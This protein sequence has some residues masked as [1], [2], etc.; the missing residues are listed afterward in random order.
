MNGY[1]TDTGCGIAEDKLSYIFEA[2]SQADASFNRQHSGIGLGL[3]LCQEYVQLMDGTITVTSVVNIGSR[4]HVLLPL[5][6]RNADVI[7]SPILAAP[8]L[9]NE[10]HKNNNAT[11][12]IVEDNIVN[13]KLLSA[14]VNKLGY[15]TDIVENGRAAVEYLSDKRVDLVFM[16]CQMPV[17][18]G[19]EATREI[20]NGNTLDPKV[21]IIAVTANVMS[22]DRQRCL[23]AGMDDY[24]KKPIHKNLIQ[25]AL[26]KY[27]T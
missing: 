19:F 18:D 22:G 16:D 1:V 12:L 26:A 10:T 3:A 17:M 2:F 8:P 7:S 15:K 11:V 25:E 27:I 24:I 6:R 21:P 5:T 4:F 9:T 13:Q 14:L 23:D 20:R